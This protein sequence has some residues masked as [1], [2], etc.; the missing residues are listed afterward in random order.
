MAKVRDDQSPNFQN[1]KASVRLPTL[2]VAE[3]LFITAVMSCAFVLRERMSD[4][5][6]SFRT[7]VTWF[8]GLH[9]IAV[10]LL[11]G[12]PLSAVF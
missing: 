1:D 11:I 8:R 4:M 3:L 12:I 2:T 9:Q 10:V 5:G 7:S 6:W